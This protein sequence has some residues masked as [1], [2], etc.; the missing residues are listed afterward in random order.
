MNVLILA[1][2]QYGD[3]QWYRERISVFSKI[4]CADGGTRLACL[5]G[6]VP[7]LVVG[8]MDSTDRQDRRTLEEAGAQFIIY[9]R[10]KDLSD[11]QIAFEQARS[12]KPSSVTVWGGTG[13]RLDHTLSTILNAFHLVQDNIDVCLDSP[14]VTIHL[15]KGNLKLSGNPGDTVSLI[16]I[17]QAATGVTL[18]GLHYPLNN[19]AL[20]GT[21]QSGISNV[22][23]GKDALIEV[24]TGHT[25]VFHYHVPA[26]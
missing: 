19:A 10:E 18:E 14:E 2:G 13:D 6:I 11:I 8:D 5:L 15:V 3:I 20:D 21:W 16:V 12:L 25:A 24:K 9:P 4:I 22:M 7:D 23:T 17:D 1:N 26:R